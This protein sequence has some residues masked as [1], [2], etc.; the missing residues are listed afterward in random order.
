[1]SVLTLILAWAAIPGVFAVAALLRIDW[2][3]RGGL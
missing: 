2:G 3:R 1:M